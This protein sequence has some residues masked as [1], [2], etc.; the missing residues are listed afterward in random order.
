MHVAGIA[1]LPALEE[2]EASNPKNPGE[3][4]SNLLSDI[5]TIKEKLSS[6]NRGRRLKAEWWQVHFGHYRDALFAS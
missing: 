2:V 6:Q 1:V 3:A 5:Q 4:L